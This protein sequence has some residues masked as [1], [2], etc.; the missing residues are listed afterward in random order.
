MDS[1]TRYLIIALVAAAIAIWLALDVIGFLLQLVLLVAAV[2]VAVAAF[3]SWQRAGEGP[4]AGP[5]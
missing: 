5:R 4:S 2:I 3:R 1:R